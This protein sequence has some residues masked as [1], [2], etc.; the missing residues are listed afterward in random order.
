MLVPYSIGNIANRNAST[1]VDDA[2]VG[3]M[4]SDEE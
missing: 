3:T 4:R 2:L 1:V